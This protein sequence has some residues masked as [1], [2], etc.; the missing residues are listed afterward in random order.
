V[1][2]D[3]EENE[4]GDDKQE[5]AEGNARD[6]TSS[7]IGQATQDSFFSGRSENNLTDPDGGSANDHGLLT[8]GSDITGEH[9]HPHT[10]SAAK[11]TKR[12]GS[13][14]RVVESP[15]STNS[16]L[17]DA[18]S[19][20]ASTGSTGKKKEK[21]TA[22]TKKKKGRH[23]DSAD[24]YEAEIERHDQ[25]GGDIGSD[26]GGQDHKRR[27]RSSRQKQQ[28]EDS[29][30]YTRGAET[31]D[32]EENEFVDDDGDDVGG[33]EP[34][35]TAK[36]RRRRG[37]EGTKRRVGSS[38]KQL[39]MAKSND[40]A[41]SS[42][43][44]NDEFGGERNG[45]KDS[46]PKSAGKKRK[47]TSVDETP[48]AGNRSLTQLGRDAKK[49]KKRE[50]SASSASSSKTLNANAEA[51]YYDSLS[52][53]SQSQPEVNVMKQ[54]T[55][56]SKG[57]KN[58][59]MGNRAPTSSGGTKTS[60]TID[61]PFMDRDP[62]IDAERQDPIDE[63]EKIQGIGVMDSDDNDDPRSASGMGHGKVLANSA[64]IASE[65]GNA[66]SSPPIDKIGE[67][68]RK[69]RQ[70]LEKGDG[71]P[72]S[73]PSVLETNLKMYEPTVKWSAQVV[74][75]AIGSSRD[76]EDDDVNV[77]ADADDAKA[78]SGEKK[79]RSRKAR[80]SEGGLDDSV[81]ASHGQYHHPVQQDNEDSDVGEFGEDSGDDLVEFR[82][83]PKEHL[84]GHRRGA[85][86]SSFESDG[87]DDDGDSEY[88]LMD[89]SVQQPRQKKRRTVG[90]SDAASTLMT[91][92]P[93]TSD[94]ASNGRGK[95]RT[96]SKRVL[97]TITT[98]LRN[99]SRQTSQE[100]KDITEALKKQAELFK[101]L[102]H[103]RSSLQSPDHFNSIL[104]SIETETETTVSTLYSSLK[105]ILSAS[106]TMESSV[107]AEGRRKRFSAL[108]TC[109]RF[110]VDVPDRNLATDIFNSFSRCGSGREGSLVVSE[111]M[112]QVLSNPKIL[113]LLLI[114]VQCQESIQKRSRPNEV[115]LNLRSQASYLS[116]ACLSLVDP[117]LAVEQILSSSPAHSSPSTSIS[118][119]VG[120]L[121]KLAASSSTMDSYPK[122]ELLLLFLVR[123]RK[124]LLAV[125][126]DGAKDSRQKIANATLKNLDKSFASAYRKKMSRL[127]MHA[128]SNSDMGESDGLSFCSWARECTKQG[129]EY[130]RTF[131]CKAVFNLKNH[132]DFG[133]R[134][135]DVDSVHINRSS[136]S[137]FVVG[138][139]TRDEEDTL[140][141]TDSSITE[142]DTDGENAT[143]A[144]STRRDRLS[145]ER[146]YGTTKLVEMHFE[147]W[148]GQGGDSAVN[149]P[150]AYVTEVG[151]ITIYLSSDG[152]RRSNLSQALDDKPQSSMIHIEIK[153]SDFAGFCDVLAA[154]GVETINDQ[155][156]EGE[157][158]SQGSVTTAPYNDEEDSNVFAQVEYNTSKI[159]G[160]P[161]LDDHSEKSD[162]DVDEDVDEDCDDDAALASQGLGDGD[163][164]DLVLDN[165]RDTSIAMETVRDEDTSSRRTENDN[166]NIA[167]DW[168]ASPDEARAS[169]RK[170]SRT[171][172]GRN[173]ADTAKPAA[174]S[175]REE[176]SL[177]KRKANDD[178]NAATED[179]SSGIG[180]KEFSS[181]AGPGTTAKKQGARR[182]HTKLGVD[183]GSAGAAAKKKQNQKQQR[184]SVNAQTR[185]VT[186]LPESS[187]AYGRHD[188]QTSTSPLPHQSDRTNG[189]SQNLDTSFARVE[190]G[191]N[192]PLASISASCCAMSV[193]GGSSTAFNIKHAASD[194]L[195]N[196]VIAY[197]VALGQAVDAL[198]H[199]R[200]LA[201]KIEDDC[202]SSTACLGTEAGNINKDEESSP[203]AFGWIDEPYNQVVEKQK[204]WVQQ[205]ESVEKELSGILLNGLLPASKHENTKKK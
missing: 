29:P 104:K 169:R 33:E 16:R 180:G 148:G 130:V 118:S 126:L 137:F 96:P 188:Q 25:E 17:S 142:D 24:D 81:L 70:R 170:P 84:G 32:D 88:Q 52:F 30:W 200:H 21:E 99:L 101:E 55:K 127:N 125:S 100:Q 78:P 193:V 75:D 50:K 147:D 117:S 121:H 10:A 6:T 18:E 44:S 15:Y 23:Y 197:D 56:R 202:R 151:A 38:T 98:K 146:L 152:M 183:Q 31:D 108:C 93:N 173:S 153:K 176:I 2:E 73:S 13:K 145:I 122:V 59:N 92:A 83:Q 65:S 74:Q 94:T 58:K 168:E 26:T 178:E 69:R 199:V 115:E 87:D 40:D 97:A 189:T 140:R 201:K 135:Q 22:S 107:G 165:E 54:P 159:R 190:R 186:P 177:G 57:A 111:D 160:A 195:A 154:R 71:A 103:M 158:G 163:E 42:D 196:D 27:R 109:L 116:C 35:A 175:K 194:D 51:D 156:Q 139:G 184:Q 86:A 204:E 119:A 106:A 77:D 90:K 7:S 179:N 9:R 157:L 1:N 95:Y 47:E 45:P 36:S 19:F 191:M 3:D 120:D 161:L 187:N 105:F 192:K 63:F 80:A 124:I 11:K 110:F 39:G 67:A 61:D 128:P 123:V 28:Q 66:E 143:A 132:D 162:E 82:T 205:R 12:T 174:A 166:E 64:G 20:Q 134:I 112:R 181:L 150:I 49:K 133:P 102:Q 113:P 89:K 34:M 5:E 171:T 198:S 43:E 85:S 182:K 136:L 8:Q 53:H 172:K 203:S 76:D 4:E 37:G 149:R 141:T 62:S 41:T 129:N 48:K 185:E 164:D 68:G 14:Q 60:D 155:T 91:I 114:A 167:S 46:T 79:G 72:F 131:G 144:T 138:A